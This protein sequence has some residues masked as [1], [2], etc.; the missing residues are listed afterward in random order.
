MN[1]TADELDRMKHA[2]AWPKCYRNHYSADLDGPDGKLWRG[3]VEK[4]MAV[5]Q[6]AMGPF[7]G[8]RGMFHVTDTGKAALAASTT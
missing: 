6:E 3:L 4:G 2:T 7:A 5:E 8:K 1:L